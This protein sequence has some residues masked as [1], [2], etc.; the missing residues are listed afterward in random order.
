MSDP[1]AARL[2]RLERQIGAFRE[3]HVREVSELAERLAAVAKLHGDELQLILDESRDL[4]AHVEEAAVVDE[5]GPAGDSAAAPRG[6]PA[7][8]SPKR[9]KWL[10]EQARPAQLT[11]R[12]LLGGRP[13]KGSE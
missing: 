4:A 6:D 8:S 1:L 3:M 12:H 13:E 11:R 2:R 10:A 7:A 5:V 9:A